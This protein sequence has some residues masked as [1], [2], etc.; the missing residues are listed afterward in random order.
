MLLLLLWCTCCWQHPGTWEDCA[1][2]L[3]LSRRRTWGFTP[4]AADHTGSPVPFAPEIAVLSVAAAHSVTPSWQG[5]SSLGRGCWL[6]AW[7]RSFWG[8]MVN[9]TKSSTGFLHSHAE[10][11][12]SFLY[13]T[14]LE[15]T[16]APPA[17]ARNH[18]LPAKQVFMPVVMMMSMM[19]SS[20]TSNRECN[21]QGYPPLWAWGAY[22]V[23]PH[24]NL[25]LCWDEPLRQGTGKKSVKKYNI[26][27]SSSWESIL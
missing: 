8:R 15:S 11:L 6:H 24:S 22:S 10:L 9:V 4:G 13:G 25:R 21:V 19:P 12:Q 5:L 14:A 27:R 18:C 1:M 16:S 7:Q 20:W 2:S 26:M 23:G 17:D 3:W